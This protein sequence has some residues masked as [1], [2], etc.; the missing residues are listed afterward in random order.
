M[1]NL[2]YIILFVL[3]IIKRIKITLLLLYLKIYQQL[4]LKKSKRLKRILM[5]GQNMK[6]QLIMMITAMLIK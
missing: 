6:Y 5:N 1:E 2:I 4:I 3:L